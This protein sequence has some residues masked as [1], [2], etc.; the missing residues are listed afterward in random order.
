M[1]Q[2]E[3]TVL[4]AMSGGV[5]SSV[6]AF[7]LKK[8]GYSVFGGT[9]RLY[10]K[11]KSGKSCGSLNDIFDAK[12]VAKKLG[13]E[14]YVLDMREDFK[15]I[16]INEFINSYSE[17]RTPNPCLTCNRFLKF[18]ALSKKAEE[19]GLSYVASGHYAII[20]KHGDR[21][22]L[23][24]GL[25]INKDQS[26][27]LYTMKQQQL[28]ETLF[29][30]GKL[31]KSEVREI[32]EQNG[33]INSKKKD[34]QDICFVHD[35]DYGGFIEKY[36]GKIFPK[37]EFVDRTG[38]VLGV[39]KGIIRYTEGQRRGLGLPMN[40]RIYVIS[41]NAETNKVVLGTNSELFQ[42]KV[43]IN[44]INLIACDELVGE[45][46][47]TAKIRYNMNDVPCIVRQINND[48]IIMEFD[49]PV[50]AVSRG[51]SA[52]IYDGETVIGGGIII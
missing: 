24:R 34:S 36:T 25:D 32:A 3:K 15:N 38:K 30:L 16:V 43:K 31:K 2:K 41:K 9:M 42:K 37:G 10:D 6:V 21:F 44:N 8:Q 27:V 46:K 19:L 13:F 39:H 20:E 18:G 50:R 17:G 51:Q 14:H 4:A 29:P 22:L 28:A 35:N 11:E 49:E 33:F 47:L 45:N 12:S 7:L 26:Y 48:E 1:M 40:E 5:D 23:K 52:V